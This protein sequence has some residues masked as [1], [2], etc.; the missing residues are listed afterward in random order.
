MS[1]LEKSG[2]LAPA[3][4]KAWIKPKVTAI[5]TIANTRTGPLIKAGVEN[6]V[7]SQS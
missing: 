6:A 5:T 2:D 3:A 7:Y 1:S 4:R